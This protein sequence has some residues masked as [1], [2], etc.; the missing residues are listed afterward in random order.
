M[1]RALIWLGLASCVS[2]SAAAQ[3]TDPPPRV[4]VVVAGELESIV[5]AF[6]EWRSGYRFDAERRP[7]ITFDDVIQA[8]ADSLA[9]VFVDATRQDTALLVVAD[10]RND[11]VLIRRFA[12]A[13]VD[14]EVLQE[15]LLQAVA[16]SLDALSSGLTIGTPRSRALAALRDAVSAD[17]TTREPGSLDVIPSPDSSASSSPDSSVGSSSDPSAAPPPRIDAAGFLAYDA[18]LAGE[19]R[20]IHGPRLGI[21]LGSSDVLWLRGF[22]EVTYHFGTHFREGGVEGRIDQLGAQVGVMVGTGAPRIDVRA[23]VGIDVALPFVS[24][25]P[26]LELTSRASVDLLAVVAVRLTHSFSDDLSLFVEAGTEL[27]L[28]RTRWRVDGRTVYEL[29]PVR[30]LLGVGV[31]VW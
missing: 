7:I 29:W 25:Q 31:Q 9:R 17:S 12:R 3:A 2:S 4:E 26:V 11:R 22:A 19:L 24:A 23:S 5:E 30:P 14:Q 18:A 20:P 1:H 16:S 28:T 27:A 10:D 13:G 6:A 15:Q 21:Q 8:G